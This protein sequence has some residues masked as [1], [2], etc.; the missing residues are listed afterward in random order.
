MEPGDPTRDRPRARETLG[1]LSALGAWAPD[2][3]VLAFLDRAESVGPPSAEPVLVHGDLHI[4]HVLVADG[5]TAPRASGVID[6]GD[7]GL[8]DPAMDLAIGFMAFAG[9]VRQAF[10]DAYGPADDERLLRAR[11]LAVH[12]SA[13]LAEQAV[14]DGMADVTAE[15]L[16]ALGRT[17][18][19]APAAGSSPVVAG[20]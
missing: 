11:T 5:R 12:L 16:A 10:L 14:G 4:R 15:S 8:G 18:D 7:T 1:R 17:S 20:R 13:A 3:K 6:W 19:D 9:P 2:P